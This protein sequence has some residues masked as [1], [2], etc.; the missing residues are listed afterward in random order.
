MG[1]E[2]RRNILG[3]KKDENVGNKLPKENTVSHAQGIF[4]ITLSASRRLA[5]VAQ[6][7]DMKK[8]FVN[9]FAY[10]LNVLPT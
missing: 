7:V 2:N 3:W 10:P 1:G 5:S 4:R 9:M 8:H 6:Y